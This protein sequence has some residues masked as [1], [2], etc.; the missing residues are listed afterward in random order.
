MVELVGGLGELGEPDGARLTSAEKD[1]D[2]A[3]ASSARGSAGSGDSAE[4]TRLL[5]ALSFTAPRNT[6]DIAARSGLSLA[7]VQSLLG[8]LELEGRVTERER[9]WVRVKTVS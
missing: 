4:T 3:A 2:A 7:G 9:G 5:D 1:G 8:R 6:G